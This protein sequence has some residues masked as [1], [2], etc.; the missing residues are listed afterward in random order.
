M[1]SSAPASGTTR[2]V[3]RVRGH[4]QRRVDN[5]HETHERGKAVPRLDHPVRR[6]VDGKEE[7]TCETWM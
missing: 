5:M 2:K 6:K 4:V 1:R 3:K 7:L